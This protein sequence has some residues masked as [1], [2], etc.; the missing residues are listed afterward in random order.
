VSKGLSAVG[1]AHDPESVLLQDI[2]HDVPNRLIILDNED[3][4]VLRCHD[5]ES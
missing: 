1:G 5:I 3:E 2:H 4:P